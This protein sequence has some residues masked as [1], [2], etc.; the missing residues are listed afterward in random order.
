MMYYSMT[1]ADMTTQLIFS[2]FVSARDDSVGAT[3][4]ALKKAGIYKNSIIVFTS[5]VSKA[6]LIS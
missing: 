3:I 4:V 5:D 2:G 6:Y 1:D